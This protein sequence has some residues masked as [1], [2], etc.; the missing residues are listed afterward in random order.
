[1]TYRKTLLLAV[2][3]SLAAA[4]ALAQARP[5][6]T[7]MSCSQAAG[8]VHARGALVLGTGVHTYDRFVRDRSFCE[9]TEYIEPGFAPTLDHP[10][11]FVGYT[12]K[13]PIGSLRQ[14]D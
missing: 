1:M 10:Q 12:C 2:A 3:L 6:S 14:Q 9:I 11:C 5:R 7:R 4:E 13:E 8:L